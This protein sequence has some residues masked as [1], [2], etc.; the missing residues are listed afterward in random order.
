MRKLISWLIKN[1]KKKERDDYN[2]QIYN[3]NLNNAMRK[4]VTTK[5][6]NKYYLSQIIRFN[7]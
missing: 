4:F 5:N 3:N 2:L 6:N 1:L 7:I